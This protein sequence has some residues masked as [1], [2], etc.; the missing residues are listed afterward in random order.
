MDNLEEINK[1]CSGC[2]ALPVCSRVCST[3]IDKA[4]I[5]SDADLDRKAWSKYDKTT[6]DGALDFLMESN[7]RRNKEIEEIGEFYR[8]LESKGP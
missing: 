5:L 8:S 1:I 3:Y 2:I 7:K 4:I 6:C